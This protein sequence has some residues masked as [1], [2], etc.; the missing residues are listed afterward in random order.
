MD[1]VFSAT[2]VVLYV[3]SHALVAGLARL[4]SEQ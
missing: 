1:A 2:V 3:L 4:R